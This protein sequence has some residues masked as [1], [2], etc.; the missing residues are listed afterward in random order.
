MKNGKKILN[1]KTQKR[2]EICQKK[3][4][5]LRP[6]VSNPPCFVRQNQQKKKRK[7]FF[8]AAILDHF[9]T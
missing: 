5:T 1:G 2:L 8:Y 7:N 3:E 6:E 4:Y 9:L